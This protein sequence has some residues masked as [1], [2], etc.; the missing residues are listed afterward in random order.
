MHG[1]DSETDDSDFESSMIAWLDLSS[2]APTSSAPDPST[3]NLCEA[4]TTAI[5]TLQ[6]VRLTDITAN[7]QDL[8]REILEASNTINKYL[9]GI[10]SQSQDSLEDLGL[11]ASLVQP[12]FLTMLFSQRR[13]FHNLAVKALAPGAVAST[14]VCWVDGLIAKFAEVTVVIACGSSMPP[15]ISHSMRT[16]FEDD[17]L[18]AAAQLPENWS[19]VPSAISSPKS[20]PAA[21]RLAIQLAF[22]VYIVG[23]R[24]QKYDPWNDYDTPQAVEFSKILNEYIVTI[25]VNES[26][27]LYATQM[28][29]DQM[30]LTYAMIISL[31]AAS[32][33]NLERPASPFRPRTLSGV[34]CM[35]QLILG[36][37]VVQEDDSTCITPCEQLDPAQILLLH[38]GDFMC[39]C[40]ETWNDYRVANAECI[41][42]LTATWLYHLQGA[43]SVPYQDIPNAHVVLDKNASAANYAMLQVLHQGVA[44]FLAAGQ[45]ATLQESFYVVLSNACRSIDHLLRNELVCGRKV[46]GAEITAKYLLGIFVLLSVKTEPDR[47]LELKATILESLTMVDEGAFDKAISDICK[48]KKIQFVER[49]DELILQS[50]RELIRSTEP[51]KELTNTQAEEL[52]L[53]LYFLIRIWH[54]IEGRSHVQRQPI[55]NL[56]ASLANR[57]LKGEMSP[58]VFNYLREAVVTGFCVLDTDPST[59]IKSPKQEDVWRFVFDVGSSDLVMTSNF[60][61]HIIT[62]PRLPDSLTCAEAWDH[63]RD[64]I[65]LIF[66]HQFMDDEQAIALLVSLGICNAMLR[67]LDADAST[68]HFILDSPWT[69]SFCVELKKVLQ[70]E[71]DESEN[72]HTQL[73]K[74]QLAPVGDVLLDALRYKLD[75]DNT[76]RVRE[77]IPIKS[78]LIYH[79]QYPDYRLLLVSR[80][81]SAN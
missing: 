57:L 18:R 16:Q 46:A 55:L 40:W 37:S 41:T 36:P 76:F 10:M 7:I 1:D 50:R 20:S 31:F 22:A 81:L 6:N 59:Y 60:A 58:Q 19:L 34:L 61:Y 66:R 65:T 12:S 47:R 73:L 35:I 44:K 77:D 2:S 26:T 4:V 5:R 64:A 38:W 17:G 69:M 71:M 54:S 3:K 39:W 13:I 51:E 32:D 68:V 67:L 72:D 75:S 43:D 15:L 80:T 25:P 14:V 21:K 53:A 63:L 33:Y 62:T 56:L 78:R 27:T 49:I 70:K 23:P 9:E 42:R 8:H 52:R 30:R 45:P 24:L 29:V 74:C 28:L 48:D 11:F 79:G